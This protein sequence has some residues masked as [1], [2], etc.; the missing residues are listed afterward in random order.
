MPNK[1]DSFTAATEISVVLGGKKHVGSWRY[2]T[3]GF[4]VQ[5]AGEEEFS[6]SKHPETLAPT[7][8]RQMVERKEAME[9]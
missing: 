3:G 6:S 7:I 4:V 1:R 5:Y 2:V 8:L 9:R